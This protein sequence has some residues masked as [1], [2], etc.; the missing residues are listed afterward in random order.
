MSRHIAPGYCVV[1]QPGT[2]DFQATMLFRDCH[3]PAA[4]LFMQNNADTPWLKPGQICR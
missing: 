2:L 3:S 1:E 4:R